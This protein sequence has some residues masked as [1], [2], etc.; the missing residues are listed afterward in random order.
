MSKKAGRIA[1]LGA[2]ALI[3]M[4]GFP[5]AKALPPAAGVAAAR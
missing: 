3:A 5:D 1:F 2:A 4:L